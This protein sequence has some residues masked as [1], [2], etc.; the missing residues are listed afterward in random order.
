MFK[1]ERIEHFEDWYVVTDKIGEF[2]TIELAIMA[3]RDE[4]TRTSQGLSPHGLNSYIQDTFGTNET[5][6]IDDY[7][8]GLMLRLQEDE[9][10]IAS[11]H[12]AYDYKTGAIESNPNIEI[13]EW[14]AEGERKQLRGQL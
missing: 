3:F 11:S 7:S 12:F 2:E 1:L 14:L 5:D 8:M 13:V 10:E 6:E 4:Y 9:Y